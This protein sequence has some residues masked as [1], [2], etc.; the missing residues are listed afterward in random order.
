MSA[1]LGLD[2]ARACDP[3]RYALGGIAPRQAVRPTSR[4]E[5]AEVLRAAAAERLTVLPW[6][7]GVALTRERAAP[8]HDVALDL[9]GLDRVIEYDPA[10]FTFTAECGVTLATLRAQ[11]AAR[12]Q[13]L[14]LEGAHAARATLG[15]VLAANA[16][17]PRRL[18]FGS[19]RDRILG[20]RF[21]LGDGSLVRTGGKVVKNVAGFGIHRM[22]CGSRGGLAVLIEASLK[23]A[24][25][26][27]RRAVLLYDTTPAALAE[28][29]RWAFLP[30]LEPALVTVLG[31]AATRGLP[32]TATGG[33]FMIAIGLEEDAPGLVEQR[34][35]VTAAL[36][37]PTRSLEGDDAAAF[38]QTLA[39]LE[40]RDGARLSFATGANTPAAL[41]PLIAHPEA[42]EFL[43]HAPAGRLHV[44]VSPERA[45]AM[46]DAA[47]AHG[48][49]LIAARGA[50][51]IAPAI[52]PQVAVLGLRARIREALDPAHR[53]A[54]GER[55]ERG[56]L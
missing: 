3:A 8:A 37:E 45:Q 39:D 54:L 47:A 50:G 10:D 2:A 25:A 40:E 46:A 32:V 51:E 49:T 14:P 34:A 13:E 31:A 18:R 55:W 16:S 36:G 56:A 17:G 42:R 52:S 38:V 35:H 53:F 20:A 29:T 43:F 6:G 9:S 28:A 15:G 7:G 27:E 33:A 26:P 5:V 44:T 23:L 4:E 24:P 48:F 12:S 21:A 1:T 30:R 11:L 19:P 22:L 41:A